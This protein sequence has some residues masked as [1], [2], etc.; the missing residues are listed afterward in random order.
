MEVE[1]VITA[2]NNKTKKDIIDLL[3]DMFENGSLDVT[4]FSNM[5]TFSDYTPQEQKIIDN[6]KNNKL[7][8]ENVEFLNQR[9]QKRENTKI[10]TI[11]SSG[12]KFDAFF[13]KAKIEYYF[14]YI[15][16]LYPRHIGKDL[17][18]KSFY[19]LIKIKKY[20]ELREYAMFVAKRIEMY[21]RQIEEY[22]TEPQ[23]IMHFS[24]FCNSKKYL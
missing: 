20:K 3:K 10:A 4:V 12:N 7:T 21:K 15:W 5:L 11:V 18:K 8:Q 6:F 19:N 13:V 16:K 23:F 22:N 1:E 17:A 9:L 2:L 24:T 14:D